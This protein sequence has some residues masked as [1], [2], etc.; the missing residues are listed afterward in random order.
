MSH[1]EYTVP[2]FCSPCTDCTALYRGRTGNAELLDRLLGIVI[3]VARS[4][5]GNEHRVNGSTAAVVVKG[6]CA[7]LDPSRTGDTLPDLIKQAEEEKYKL[8]PGCASCAMPC[9]RT[10]NY[11]MRR[12]W[13]AEETTLSLKTLLL[14]AA[15]GI[16]LNAS[17]K[18]AKDI[19]DQ[20]ISQYL[21]DLLFAIGMD[22]WGTDELL[23]LIVQTGKIAR[24]F[25]ADQY[26]ADGKEDLLARITG[27][28]TENL[29]HLMAQSPCKAVSIYTKDDFP[30]ACLTADVLHT[31]AAL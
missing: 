17:R 10:E 1:L 18:T 26:T 15:R 12:L 16:A 20:T 22:D 5:Y 8:A 21:Y 24:C 3:G 23:P 25:S 27:Q 11:D 2:T 4:T 29:K 31:L 19:Y 30:P 13:A 6:L 7:T 28:K 9:G 14:F